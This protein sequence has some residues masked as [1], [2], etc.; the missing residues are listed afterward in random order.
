MTDTIY[1]YKYTDT[2]IDTE[3]NTYTIHRHTHAHA[4][5]HSWLSVGSSMWMAQYSPNTYQK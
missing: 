3:E 4:K 1:R 2:E 5:I